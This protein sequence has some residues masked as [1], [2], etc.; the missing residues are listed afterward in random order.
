[1][2]NSRPDRQTD[3]DILFINFILFLLRKPYECMVEDRKELRDE[4]TFRKV[5]KLGINS[6]AVEC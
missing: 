2:G 6:T 1:M 5:E 3:R 4:S